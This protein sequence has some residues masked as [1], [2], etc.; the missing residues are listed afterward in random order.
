MSQHVGIVIAVQGI[1]MLLQ[2][3]AELGAQYRAERSCAP[4]TAPPTTSTTW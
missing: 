2:V 4:P 3:V 1:A